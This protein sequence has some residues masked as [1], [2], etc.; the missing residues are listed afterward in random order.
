MTLTLSIP[1]GGRGCVSH[2][3]NGW[4]ENFHRLTPRPVRG[5]LMISKQ[6]RKPFGTLQ[7]KAEERLSHERLSQRKF[8]RHTHGWTK[9]LQ[10]VFGFLPVTSHGMKAM[11]LEAQTQWTFGID[12]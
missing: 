3:K 1:N 6:W 2:E 9:S 4:A 7:R 10:T 8:L 11:I 5:G 12:T